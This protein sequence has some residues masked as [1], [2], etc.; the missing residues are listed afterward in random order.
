[1]DNK[2]EVTYINNQDDFFDYSLFEKYWDC[3]DNKKLL[4]QK[5]KKQ[6]IFLFICARVVVFVPVIDISYLV[7]VLVFLL[8][9][10]LHFLYQNYLGYLNDYRNLVRLRD[11]SKSK[12]VVNVYDEK[13]TL[14]IDDE[15]L[16]LVSDLQHRYF[17]WLDIEYIQEI[18]NLIVFK[19]RLSSKP[20]MQ[21]FE[22]VCIAKRYI[23]PEKIQKIRDIVNQKREKYRIP[24]LLPGYDEQ[25][26]KE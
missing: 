22:K 20:E 4:P 26:G 25:V 19:M 8:L 3:L 17:T 16:E 12:N 9:A 6:I 1:M 18:E 10:V 23:F 5:L 13:F 7:L 14:T 24:E 21:G 11:E 2:I 15:E